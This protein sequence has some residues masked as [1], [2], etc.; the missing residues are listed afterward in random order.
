MFGRGNFRDC[1]TDSMKAKGFGKERTQK[2][3]EDFDRRAKAY[4]QQGMPHPDADVAAMRDTF[5]MLISDNREAAKRAAKDL[6]VTAAIRERA[7]QWQNIKTSVFALDG[8]KGGYGVQIARAGVSL[9][10]HDPRAK[11]VDFETMRRS[12]LS[13]YRALLS[14]VLDNFSKGAFGRQVGTAHLPNIIRELFGTDTGDKAAKQIGVALKKIQNTM[15]DDFNMAGG[16]LRKL[17]NYVAPQKQSPV[18]VTRIGPKSWIEDHNGWLDWGK[19]RWPNGDVIEPAERATLLNEVYT[20]MATDGATN[21]RP[22]QVKSKMGGAV[23]NMLEKHRF[24]IYKDADSW[25]AMHEKYGDGNVFDV[26]QGHMAAMAHKTALVNQFGANPDIAL[27]RIEA[28]LLSE[29]G[30]VQRTA[31][32]LND[33]KGLNV[34]DEVKTLIRTKIEPMHKLMTHQNPVDVNSFMANSLQ[35]TSHVLTAAQLGGILFISMPSDF[36]TTVATRLINHMPLLSG[37][38]TYMKAMLPGG[39]GNMQRIA[40]RAGY[41][42][43]ET[44]S[45]TYAAERFTGLGTYGPALSSRLSDATMRL[46]M[47]TRHTNIA[48]GT[49]ALEHMGMLDEYRG[50]SF[51]QLPNKL[52][53]ERYGIT[54]KEWDAVRKLK[55][56]SPNGSATYMRPLDILEQTDWITKQDTYNKFFNMIDSE[57]RVMVPG[58][59][60]EGSMLLRGTSRPDTLSGALLHSFG[61]Y[62]NFPAS[63]MMLYGRQG[64][65]AQNRRIGFYAALGVGGIGAGAL[66][67][68]LKEISKGRTPLPMDTVGFWGKAVATSGALSLW[69]DYLFGGVN[70]QG[71][72][73][74]EMMAGPI[75][76]LAAD[77]INLTL[78]DGYAW[79]EA[80]DRGKAFDSKFGGRLAEY[81]KRYTPGTNIWWARLALERE[82]WDKLQMQLDKNAQ[83]KFRR[84]VRMQQ[85]NY[86]NTYWAPPGEDLITG[87]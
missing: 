79:T 7:M 60:V 15:V 42:F 53:M 82:V 1:I 68:Q 30:N 59:T 86:G 3:L 78:G 77:T 69:G 54:S 4:D 72:G 18:K 28:T 44:F 76:G 48:R 35:T 23:G 50:L 64:L 61:M 32:S 85:Q 62:K 81:A 47:I 22:G 24:L 58:A 27:A 20:V 70:Q 56:W 8:K 49:V 63:M 43:D 80:L 84:R 52:I 40:T 31:I 73:P 46:G 71:R 19:M 87:R 33:P 11:G 6:A 37:I 39:Y 13:K 2:I 29:A 36:V 17:T 5:N 57:S 14:D 41:A 67:L 21:I 51:D 66:A 10:Q 9:Y 45:G 83:K 34:V 26:M 16:S 74:A 55:P 75:G 12:Y 65:A 38:G 25:L